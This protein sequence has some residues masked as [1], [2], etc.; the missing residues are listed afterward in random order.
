MRRRECRHVRPGQRAPASRP[1]CSGAG[2][3]AGP[4]GAAS[5]DHRFVRPSYRIFLTD[6]TRYQLRRIR[7]HRRRSCSRSDRAPRPRR[8]P[9]GVA[10]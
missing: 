3:L 8:A 5:R 1:S 6:G 4:A 2:A 7:A 9:G 10:P